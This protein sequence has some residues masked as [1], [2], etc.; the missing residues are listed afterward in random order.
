MTKKQKK[1]RDEIA[2]AISDKDMK[3]RYGDKNIKWAIATKL[4]MKESTILSSIGKSAL[5]IIDEGIFDFLPKQKTKMKPGG[6]G[7][8]NLSDQEKKKYKMPIIQDKPP[9]G[10]YRMP[11]LPQPTTKPDPYKTTLV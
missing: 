5:K 11:M 6:V 2:D 8:D 9:R 3:D 4:A 7:I 10:G 1:K